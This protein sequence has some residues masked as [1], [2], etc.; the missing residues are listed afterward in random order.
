MK[1]LSLVLV[2]VFFVLMVSMSAQAQDSTQPEIQIIE[3]F[4]VQILDGT[5]DFGVSWESISC[6][7]GVEQTHFALSNE[8]EFLN[9]T[10]IGYGPQFYLLEESPENA[11]NPA[12]YSRNMIRLNGEYDGNTCFTAI[13]ADNEFDIY[14]AVDGVL[15]YSIQL[16]CDNQKSFTT[17]EQ[18]WQYVEWTFGEKAISNMNQYLAEIIAEN[19]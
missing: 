15:S 11:F 12:T 4:L 7:L 14:V 13:F 8:T 10:N 5:S 18:F 6:F 1:K 9:L 17:S 3:C 19:R 16:N 2:V